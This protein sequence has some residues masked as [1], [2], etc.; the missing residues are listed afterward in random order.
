MSLFASEILAGGKTKREASI[1]EDVHQIE[2][3]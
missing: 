1:S 2:L 3:F